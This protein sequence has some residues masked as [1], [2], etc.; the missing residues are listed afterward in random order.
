MG[1]QDS[2]VALASGALPSAIAVV[3]VSGPKCADIVERFL[4]NPPPPRRLA[5]SLIVDPDSG[6]VI[7]RGMAVRW[8]GPGSFTGEDCLEFHVHGSKP[9]V[10]NLLKCL[11]KMPTVR[12][13]EPG[14]FA[15][16]AFENGRLDLTQVEGLGDL[17]VAETESQ[18]V[19]ALARM[20]GGLA[21]RLNG[22]RQQLLSCVAGVEAR[23]DFSDE[24][25]VGE[26]DIEQLRDELARIADEFGST[27]A[28]FDY[29]RIVREGFRVGIGGAPNVGKSSLINYLVG[30]D[31]AIVTDEAGTTRDVNEVAVDLD[32]HK[33]IFFDGAGIRDAVGKAEIEGIRRAKRM[34]ERSDLVIW[35]RTAHG[36]EASYRPGASNLVEVVNKCDLAAA[37]GSGMAISVKTGVGMEALLAMIG[38]KARENNTV[39]GAA[40]I[41]HARDRDAIVAGLEALEA[42]KNLLVSDLT[43]AALE[44]VAEELRLAV[45]SLQRLLGAVD[46]ENVLD[47]LFHDFC[48]GK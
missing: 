32:G 42:A 1:V 4:L 40:L 11:Q 30:S 14:E 41:S 2:I 27:L 34:L 45:F 26:A 46:A 6:D 39:A 18:R 29:G 19:Q 47:R 44:L 33:V 21:D 7:D 35:M 48:I 16:R 36:T 3:R 15:R 43:G 37:T 20:N 10:A 17:V 13:A 31:V 8:P 9:V 38:E 5:L 28:G 25:D 24:E 22:W 23:L 12:L